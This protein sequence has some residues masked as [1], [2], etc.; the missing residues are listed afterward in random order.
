[1][2]RSL[3]G[4]VVRRRPP[5]A[6]AHSHSH[7]R[8]RVAP[9]SLSLAA[10]REASV[11]VPVCA[12]GPP[13]PAAGGGTWFPVRRVP[14]RRPGVGAQALPRPAPLDVVGR[15]PRAGPGATAARKEPPRAAA[16]PQAERRGG[17]GG[18]GARG[19]RLGLCPRRLPA[20]SRLNP[21]PEAPDGTGGR[22]R[23][24]EPPPPPRTAGSRCLGLTV[25]L[26][27]RQRQG[28]VFFP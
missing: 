5:L 17:C 7:R 27:M 3:L 23:A 2:P 25:Y 19:A 10:T 20:A 16:G 15:E 22:A 13:P 12:R 4:N 1:M 28:V 14:R 26:K 18:R 8:F 24:G 6:Q 11:R 21:A 9:C